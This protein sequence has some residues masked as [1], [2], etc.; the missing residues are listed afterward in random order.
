V[1]RKPSHPRSHLHPDPQVAP[2]H[3]VEVGKRL[4]ATSAEIPHEALRFLGRRVLPP[5][6]GP[7][8]GAVPGAMVVPA[9]APKPTVRV[10]VYGPEGL[11]EHVVPDAPDLVALLDPRATT[12]IDVE[13]FGDPDLLTRIGEALGIHPLA[14]ADVVHVPQRPKAELYD[15]RLLL[16]MQMARIT[17]DGNVDVEQ[18]SLVLGPGWVVTFQERAGDVF[19]PIRARIRSGAS[20]MRQ[21]GA[22]YLAYTLLDAVIDGYFPVIEALGGVVD[23]LEEEV[24]ERP[25]RAT[26]TRIHATRRALLGLHRVQWRQRDAISAMLRDEALPIS[27]GVKPYLRDA[28]DHAFQTLDVIESYRDMMVGLVDLHISSANNRLNEVMKT[29][30]VVATIFIPLTFVVGV[31]GMNFQYMPELRWRFAYP[32]V[33]AAMVAIAVGLVAWFRRRGWIGRDL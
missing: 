25:T 1:A 3:H 18:L 12:W 2:S 20:R 30:T 19:D 10:L 14:M 6:R 9:G 13:G 28:H 4:V 8:S 22:D 5:R 23:A 31:Y 15:D 16:V 29:L 26:L 21:L 11:Q 7:P 32:A 24:V 17:P 27:P 33:W